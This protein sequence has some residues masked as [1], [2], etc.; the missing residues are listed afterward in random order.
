MPTSDFGFPLENTGLRGARP[1]SHPR[2]RLALTLPGSGR[3]STAIQSKMELSAPRNELLQSSW[4]KGS[5]GPLMTTN[6][7]LA[8]GLNLS[9]QSMSSPNLSS[10]CNSILNS[11]S[12]MTSYSFLENKS[13][14]TSFSDQLISSPASKTLLTTNSCL[15]AELACSA[16]TSNMLS[17]P[18]YAVSSL[19]SLSAEAAVHLNTSSATQLDSSSI[20]LSTKQD[21][22]SVSPLLSDETMKLNS[23]LIPKVETSSLSHTGLPNT[24]LQDV[25]SKSTV[26][27]PTIHGRITSEP[28]STL[29]VDQSK[30]RDSQDDV[31]DDTFLPVYLE[32]WEQSE[33]VS[34][35]QAE[36]A[37]S[38]PLAQEQVKPMEKEPDILDIEKSDSL[39]KQKK[40]A[41]ISAVCCSL[42][43]SPKF[44]DSSDITR[45]DIK[46]LCED[47]AQF[48]PE[49]ILKVALYTRQEL[50]IRTTANFLLAVSAFLPTCQPH[51]RRYLGSSVQLPSDWMDVPRMYQS[52]AGKEDKLAPLPSCL[53]RALTLK[54][55]EFSEYQLA[56]YNTRKQRGK[57]ASKKKKEKKTSV[58]R[59][60]KFGKK[61]RT[62]ENL[63][64]LLENQPE[65][66]TPA[67]KKTKD[68][69]S[70]KHLIQRLHISKPANHVMSLLGCRYPK[71]LNSFSRSG[72]E[73]PWQSDLSGQRMKLTQPVTW[74]RELSQKGNTGPVWEYLIDNHKVPFMALLRNLRNLI[75][76]GVSGKHHKEVNAR[77]SNKNLVIKSRLFP[78]RF[79]S[80]YK[81]IKDLECQLEKAEEPFP[82]NTVLLQRLFRREKKTFP[83][84]AWRRFSRRE[85]RACMA[86][87]VIHR[88]L[89]REKEAIRKARVIKFNKGVVEKYKQSLEEAI[90]I[91]AQHNIPPIPGRTV[92]LMS[93]D[94]SMYASCHG[95]KELAISKEVSDTRRSPPTLLDVGFLL[96]LM[97]KDTAENAQ[98]LLYNEHHYV[99]VDNSS[100]PLL[101]RVSE[102]NRQV[103]EMGNIIRQ[104]FEERNPLAEYL[105]ELLM[106]RTKVDTL[107]IFE[108]SPLNEEFKTVLKHYR[109]IV[110]P[111]CL[112]VTVL[113]NGCT[114]EDSLDQCND[115]TLC[116][117][118]EQ[119]L[120]YVSERGTSR[121]LDH[122]EKVN[123]R[124]NIP[125][126][127]D[128]IKKRHAGASSLLTSVPKQRWRSVRVFISSTFR[129]MH[130]ERDLL[131]GQVMPQLRQRAAC[132]FLSLEEVDLRWGITEEEAKK[133]RQLSLCLSEVVRSQIFIGILGERYGHVPKAY[134]LPL[135]PEYQWMQTYPVGR[136][137]TELEAMQFLQSCKTS[138]SGHPNA[139]FY[140]RNP[141]AI[142]SVPN[143]WLSDFASESQEAEK[144]ML[145]LKNRV[146]KHPAAMNY[147][148]S[149]QWGGEN[150]GKPYMAG[151]EDF[152]TRV[153]NDVWQ[154]IERDYLK[155]GSNLSEDD[156]DQLTQEGFQ[157]WHERNSFARSKQVMQVCAQ[158][159]EKRRAAPT[160]GRLFLVVGEP[161]Q[162]KTVFMA[163]LV[164]ELRLVSSSSVLY[165]FTGATHRSKDAETMLKSFC[166]QLNKRLQREIK[167]LD[168]YR[169]ALAEF[170]ALLLLVSRSLKRNNTLTLLIDG[171]D[172]LCG[173]AGELTSDWIPDIFPQRVN[174][175]LSVTEGSSLCGTLSKRK[176]I[177]VIPLG[178]LEPS[179]RA[180]LVRGKLAVYGKKLEESAFNNQMRLLMIK[181]GTRDPLYLTLACEELRAN[182]IF[183]KLSEDLQKLPATLPQLLQK[184]L[185]CLEE[186]HGLDNVTV[187]LTAICISRKGL[188]ERDLLRILSSLQ[189]IGS[190]Y[191]ANWAEMLS[192]ASHTDNLPMA[193]FSL[194]LGG[195][196]SVLGLW[197]HNL[198][199]EPRLHLSSC[200]LREAVEKR[201]FGKPE[202]VHAVHLL[203]A[204]HFWIV[205]SPMEPDS[206]PVLHAEC[207]SELSHHL[208][209]AMQLHTL[210]QLLV[211]LPFLRAHANLGFLPHLCQVYS[212]YGIAFSKRFS[213]WENM[214]TDPPAPEPPVRV[215]REFI[216]RS[217]HILSQNPS[218]F[219]QLALNEPECSPVCIQAQEI[220]AE[221]KSSEDQFIT[222]WDNKQTTVNYCSSKSLDVPSTPGCVGLSC[223]GDLAVVGTSDGSLHILHTDSGEEIRTLYSGCDGVSCCAFISDTLLSVGSYDGTLEIWN[224]T[225]GCRIHRI[226]AHRRPVTGCCVSDDR[227]Q[228]LTCSLDCDIKLWDTSRCTLIGSS[229]FPSPLNCA[230]FHPSRHVIS[231]G[232]WDGNVSVVQLDNWERSAVLCGSSSVRTVSFSLDGNVVVSGSLDGW[233]SLW[234]WEAQV[235]LSRFKAHSGYTLTSN[236]L[237][238]GEYLLTG[239][240][241]GKVQVSSGGLGRLH[242]QGCVKTALSPAL[243]VAVS[244]DRKQFAVGYHSDSVNI[245]NI[246][247][248]DLVSQ[249]PFEN[250]SVDSL[251]WLADNTLVTGSSDSFIRVWNILPGQSSCRLTLSGHQRP[252]QALALSPQ[253]LA[254]ASEDVSICLWS[255]DNLTMAVPLVSPVS[256]L[257]GHNAAVTCC[258]FSPAG[259]LLA[260][261]GKDRSLLC[262]DVS[263]NPPVLAHSLL[264]CHKDWVTCCSWT[265]NSM[266]VSSSGDGSVCLWDIQNE[267]QLLTFSGHQSAVSSALCMGERVITTGRD[268]FLKV[269]SL[270]GTEITSIPTH[271]NQINQSTAYWDPEHSRDDAD[272][273]VYTAGSDAMVLKW[274]PLQMEQIQTLHGHGAAIVSSA[275]DPQLEVTVTA[276]QDGSVRLW[277][278]PCRDESLL[279][280]SHKGAVT[281]VAWSP[282]GELVVSGGECGDIIVRDQL[283]TL[284]TLQ[285]GEL[286]IT[287]VI[288]TTKRSFCC[289]SSDLTISRWLLFP[290]KEGGLRGKKAYSVAV[291]SLVLSAVLTSLKK[292]QLKMLSGKDFLLDP[293]TGSLQD[294]N[295]IAS[296]PDPHV[297]PPQ[298]D[299]RPGSIITV[300]HPH[301]G[302][303]DSVG[304]LWLKTLESSSQ[305]T[306]DTWEQKQ[307]HAASISCLN[308]MDN[309][310]ITASSDHTVKIWKRSP[311]T[312]VGVF[313]CEGAV[314]C[315]SPYPMAGSDT[316]SMVCKIAC[317]D[318]YGKL[319][320]LT[321]LTT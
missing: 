137:I 69:F 284:L 194:L 36:S 128:N 29:I 41:L 212:S 171:A 30:E 18:N 286:C 320:L 35:T 158:I 249:C 219:Y 228:I 100:S 28:Q 245:Y 300:S 97:V 173:C 196:R 283:K 293:K 44:T 262:W 116:G 197:S 319:Y 150:D 167:S 74:E 180:E 310:V 240:E 143:H 214:E 311:F 63:C 299:L 91:S 17:S 305:S 165:H 112:C 102:L 208:L 279:T 192:A 168:S 230:A 275:A 233:V 269:W 87:P 19:S 79:L 295:V 166:K 49:F 193:T 136:S 124:F 101:E 13:L 50:N 123:E 195:L 67:E 298:E 20:S 96:S 154:V 84:N 66:P 58:V 82:S 274:S 89:K 60:L 170:Q 104:P 216:E 254:S 140:F 278:V 238:H 25:S 46:D 26:T 8:N 174:I 109:R 203:V 77:L 177:T 3:F 242:A 131:I 160:T 45:A 266:L 126:D 318:Q 294:V 303:C 23:T 6:S 103:D 304:T 276:A 21:T 57:H 1:I 191:N 204:A 244:P 163:D 236:F 265:D 146:A 94:S 61:L 198:T 186:E 122:V 27:K 316:S 232:S 268:G 129:D 229:S 9:P 234:S 321:C 134:S 281:A 199:S 178:R 314:T 264:S 39:L 56:K 47:I 231:V 272:L 206:S 210:G 114:S 42:V 65:P 98:M 68:K 95:A 142:R 225:D 153:L 105:S 81:V 120:K 237:Q 181:K 247:N 52:L 271:H 108:H 218:L 287:S 235:L 307:I 139:L 224:I 72:L 135:L 187:A 263:V 119:V 15:T 75:R 118:T 246:D 40:M 259:N 111:D 33:E 189:N 277:G 164:K 207:L 221:W 149:C 73:G 202:V 43:N 145:D 161:S 34:M 133:D 297:H 93:V 107:L 267:K 151:L 70:M 250:V 227:R 7:I 239:G 48:D 200:L 71:D 110:N 223:K 159:L 306:A 37:E 99:L 12:S 88:L 38:E 185:S 288:F 296:P 209:C 5:L 261:G 51:L 31:L 147:L 14:S 273:V 226:E 92:I 175:V 190:I 162:G 127:P 253:F 172:V 317:G 138:K 121:L 301:F 22:I 291:E 80:A 16:L 157:E 2:R 315:L 106:K 54:F 11:G 255:V 183:E 130:S 85:L 148:Y 113:P 258:A 55:Q 285:C 90:Q 188:L 308:V 83:G 10:T 248:G 125:E 292:V 217:L 302:V 53:R 241:D 220:L 78:F 309:L 152:G 222:A 205:S 280:T 24:H 290:C 251:V 4:E 211:H 282:D 155:E 270:T 115:V 179:E 176:G 256:V 213:S 289:V 144:H 201:Y 182:A 62:L 59:G 313:Y 117:F 141:E 169:D 32:Q 260:T 252:V 132:H 243:S 184:R 215:F 64:K 76:A 86:I 156:E 312:Q 257:R